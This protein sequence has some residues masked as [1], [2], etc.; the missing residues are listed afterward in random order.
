M[1]ALITGLIFFVI[2]SALVLIHEAG[3]YFAALKAGIKV[4]EFGFGLP[5][6]LWGI[7]RGE[8]EFT[9]NALPIGGFVRLYGE[10]PDG[11]SVR[12]DGKTE[13]IDQ[14]RTFLSKSLWA[15]AGVLLAGVTSNLV[16]GML[17]F[18]VVYT[19]GLPQFGVK[20]VI[21]QIAPNSPAALAG[22]K[23]GETIVSLDGT[24][25][26]DL[27]PGFSEVIQQHKGQP[28]TL[29][30]E[31]DGQ[32]RQLAVTPRQQAPAGEGLLGVVLK[33][34]PYV[35]KVER[36]PFYKA[37]L[38]GVTQALAFA[39]L[40]FTSLGGIVGGFFSHG[41]VPS[42]LA[43][44]VGI[45]TQLGVAR[46]LGAVLVLWFAG[47][48]SINLA[49]VNVLPFPALDG[50]RLL[51]VAIEAVTRRKVNPNVERWVHTIGMAVLLTLIALITISDIRKLF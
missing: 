36:Y 25:Y 24:P 41:T 35:A 22:M 13:P 27:K 4:E 12:A 45:A 21:D 7:K 32:K 19:I 6:R 33:G 44:P 11:V 49:V 39:G 9:L 47:I 37:P 42:D 26:N 2:L 51:F 10:T 17:I 23:K 34:D 14:T 43:G 38:V 30:L 28:L 1:D 5:P 29:I 48:L 50:G 18:M 20:P 8:T 3:H 15:R 16:L 40:I 46:H 31:K